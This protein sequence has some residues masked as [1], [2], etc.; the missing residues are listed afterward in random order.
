MEAIKFGSYLL[1]NQVLTEQTSKQIVEEALR[2]R[3]KASK[4]SR[5]LLDHALRSIIPG[6]FRDAAKAPLEVQVR[7]VLKHFR[8]SH[9]L[10]RIVLS[11]WCQANNS[12]YQVVRQFLVTRNP[13]I[14]SADELPVGLTGQWQE[15]EL[16]EFTKNF[17]FENPDRSL[18]E[19][20][21]MLCLV[22][23]RAPT[24]RNESEKEQIDEPE[25]AQPDPQEEDYSPSLDVTFDSFLQQLEAATPD[26]TAWERLED[27]IGQAQQLAETKR[28]QRDEERN[29]LREA[30][31]DLIS[32]HEYLLTGYF[33]IDCK[34][35]DPISC[36]H[37]ESVRI[38][39]RIKS[40]FG[41]LSEYRT[42]TAQQPS[43][44]AET[45]NW[46][47]RL[48]ILEDKV[49]PLCQEIA[50]FLAPISPPT[51]PSD[52]RPKSE[53]QTTDNQVEEPAG[54]SECESPSEST[55]EAKSVQKH[56]ELKD[57]ESKSEPNRQ[58]AETREM[59]G[60]DAMDSNL[61]GTFVGSSTVPRQ[62]DN[63]QIVHLSKKVAPEVNQPPPNEPPMPVEAVSAL[64]AP[65][66]VE[67]MPLFPDLEAPW[68]DPPFAPQPDASLEIKE[69]L[70]SSIGTGQELALQPSPESIQISTGGSEGATVEESPHVNA[71]IDV[72][73][74]QSSIGTPVSPQPLV[75][76]KED[77][78]LIEAKEELQSRIGTGQEL[79]LQPSPESIQISTGGSEGATVEESPHVNAEIDVPPDQSS[80]GTPV[81]PQPLVTPKEDE[82]L[83]EAK[84]PIPASA[85]TER[86]WSYLAHGDAAAAYCIAHSQQLNGIEPELPSQLL[87]LCSV[88]LT[89]LA[90]L[91]NSAI[92]QASLKYDRQLRTMDLEYEEMK[93]T[94]S[95]DS[96][97]RAHEIALQDALRCLRIAAALQ[98][99]LFSDFPYPDIWLQPP[100]TAPEL[101]A[102]ADRLLRVHHETGKLDPLLWLDIRIWLSLR[103][104]YSWDQEMYTEYVSP[105]RNDARVIKSLQRDFE[106]LLRH[107]EGD[108][109]QWIKI[110][111]DDQW[112]RF[113][114]VEQFER[115]WED[116][117]WV[118]ERIWQVTQS[119]FTRQEIG[120]SWGPL[121][122][123][124]RKRLMEN[125]G[126]LLEISR[127]WR[128][129]VKPP[130][131]NSTA[132]HRQHLSKAARCG[133]LVEDLQKELPNLIRLAM[134]LTVTTGTY[135][136]IGAGF[137][138]KALTM[139][140]KILNQA[141]SRDGQANP[142]LIV[143]ER[144]WAYPA[145]A[146]D[147]SG[148][149]LDGQAEQVL[150]CLSGDS[151]TD[152][153]RCSALDTFLLRGDV[154]G[155]ERLVQQL[156]DNVRPMALDRLRI[157][158]LEIV[159]QNKQCADELQRE[160][161]ELQ[162]V[163]WIGEAEYSVYSDVLK[164]SL[165][166]H[167]ISGPETSK[168]LGMIKH[169]LE[170]CRNKHEQG[171][172]ARIM[173]L[174]QRVTE[175]QIVD[176]VKT[177]SLEV[178]ERLITQ[179]AWRDMSELEIQAT[180][181]LNQGVSLDK[182]LGSLFSTVGASTTDE[183]ARFIKCYADYDRLLREH[184]FGA[185]VNA[186]RTGYAPLGMSSGEKLTEDL[187]AWLDLR[188]ALSGSDTLTV[189]RRVSRVLDFVGFSAPEIK[190]SQP[191]PESI[192]KIIYISVT[193][194]TSASPVPQFGSRTK[195]TYQIAIASD[196][197]NMEQILAR[198]RQD[199][200]PYILFYCGAL[201]LEQRRDFGAKLRNNLR[202]TLILDDI[203][204]VHLATKPEPRETV[205]FACA[206]PFGALNPYCSELSERVEPEMFFGRAN[207]ADLIFGE[208]LPMIVLYGGRQLGK[209]ALLLEVKRRAERKSNLIS[210]LHILRGDSPSSIWSML[211]DRLRR[212]GLIPEPNPT[213]KLSTVEPRIK[214]ALA[215]NP[216]RSVL[217]M[218]DE[219]DQM[220][221]S[222]MQ[223]GSANI[224]ALGRIV[225]ETGG[226]FKVVLAGNY[227]TQRYA[228]ENGTLETFHRLMIGPLEFAD[229][230]NLIRRPLG[231]LGYSFDGEP[232]WQA[233]QRILFYTFCQ[234]GLLQLFLHH[235]VQYLREL[236]SRPLPFQIR[237]EDVESA[238][239]ADNFAVVKKIQNRFHKTIELDIEY[240]LILMTLLLHSEDDSTRYFSIPGIHKL[241]REQWPK[242][243]AKVLDRHHGS[244]PDLESKWLR[245]RLEEMAGFGVLLQWEKQG[246]S[247]FRIAGESLSG[248]YGGIDA[249]RTQLKKLSTEDPTELDRM[250][251]WHAMPDPPNRQFSPLSYADRSLLASKPLVCIAGCAAAGADLLQKELKNLAWMRG[252]DALVPVPATVSDA[253][254]FGSWFRNSFVHQTEDSGR[255]YV[256]HRVTADQARQF[257]DLLGV[258]AEYTAHQRLS[259][260]WFQV[261]PIELYEILASGVA[262]PNTVYLGPWPMEAIRARLSDQGRLAKRDEAEAVLKVTGGWPLLLD[263]LDTG[264]DDKRSKA[265]KVVERR[266]EEH[267]RTLVTSFLSCLQLPIGHLLHKAI[268][269][270]CKEPIFTQ[271][272][273][274]WLS[275]CGAAS[276]REQV[277][278]KLTLQR[279]GY[280]HIDDKAEDGLTAVEPV[281]CR[282]WKSQVS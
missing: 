213:L 102:I 21:L 204:M 12:L 240:E 116:E 174:S 53:E 155:G 72:P 145:L 269:K 119:E 281:L 195:E 141:P 149:L 122:G 108:L 132:E 83:I 205:F 22:T 118:A 151:L 280:I 58:D 11:V 238:A 91:D 275:G 138:A 146:F 106:F 267:D 43:N 121:T 209:S 97:S 154:R 94:E 161:N 61:N 229:A 239:Q 168:A 164:E 218:L 208:K 69:E 115:N 86:M 57:S 163:G 211:D 126:D 34:H 176:Q 8:E 78:H 107:E 114:E 110:I 203:L 32:E 244:A 5:S 221:S 14:F 104:I 10:V 182:R 54:R 71:E 170:Q 7:S 282:I 242:G 227:H 76:P 18:D 67:E 260:V 120:R 19:A 196:E 188:D 25:D 200:W 186:V 187:K 279:L 270:L 236:P 251:C 139:L 179:N 65:D 39:E 223:S 232:G 142:S 144:L 258:A 75:T 225:I 101:E 185:L 44:L 46:R 68:M 84:E 215:A 169:E 85:F 148:N 81:S 237:P 51:L 3:T 254:A 73:P 159:K 234:A 140:G 261:G 113:D 98:P 273:E 262:L 23:G 63:G 45:R 222:E 171:I 210:I 26:S 202:S 80:I 157:A 95:E 177:H 66:P 24:S 123:G 38:R 100:R 143:A 271:D 124:A 175:A 133:K 134:D 50:N 178:I 162:A 15:G 253:A 276:E 274:E 214:A 33:R 105:G 131:G 181:I 93:L 1:L 277:A 268:E 35:W 60:N 128:R 125:M 13:S 245:A 217:L 135:L 2:F 153:E 48:S 173:A 6:G 150:E 9:S 224:T 219:V 79:A 233:I 197:L 89:S 49:L 152:E 127:E 206:V 172:R 278:V 184:P 191:Q 194:S 4:S 129:W 198:L 156:P 230:V 41:L 82:H 201:T 112:T 77:E 192:G 92:Y 74:D 111:R 183:L 231:A 272:T 64:T 158:A 117:N 147:A 259:G 109:N 212:E 17:L 28:K 216:D 96:G 87:L 235:L 130:N 55:S 228:R 249:I 36:I 256:L 37:S 90:G 199:R 193:R 29:A 40:L 189:H 255:Y 47:E 16:E 30:L 264:S 27:V 167:S 160:L 137:L 42:L 166:Q 220:L 70:Q 31:R 88:A 257:D 59:P 20:Q 136:A 247:L 62:N 243:I 207:E 226:R 248:I 165:D 250:E 266:I 190:R 103:R 99:V 263:T 56:F 52:P 252:A 180:R 246:E 265:L 241:L